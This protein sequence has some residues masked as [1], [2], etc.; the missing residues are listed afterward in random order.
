MIC[1]EMLCV[2][3]YFHVTQGRPSAAAVNLIVDLSYLKESQ[4]DN[5][6]KLL[7]VKNGK[8]KAEGVVASYILRN[9]G[10]ASGEISS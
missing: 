4:K 2:L 9:L 8:K 3:E 7:V 5:E 6:T 10:R 1:G